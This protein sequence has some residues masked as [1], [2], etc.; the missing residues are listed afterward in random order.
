M[1]L[2]LLRKPLPQKL[3][4][5]IHIILNTGAQQAKAI[6]INHLEHVL[7][8]FQIIITALIAMHENHQIVHTQQRIMRSECGR[9]EVL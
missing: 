6:G 8:N 4:S 9:V 1:F 3:N 5:L 2:N 7:G